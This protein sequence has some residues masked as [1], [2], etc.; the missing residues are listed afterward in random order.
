MTKRNSM[1]WRL[2]HTMIIGTLLLM[3]TQLLI[4]GGYILWVSVN[5]Q[6]HQQQQAAGALQ[7]ELQQRLQQLQQTTAQL[8]SWDDTYIFVNNANLD[9]VTR[10]MSRERL[11]RAG[12]FAVLLVDTS[13]G[14]IFGNSS[15][16]RHS[17]NP[18]VQATQRDLP[19]DLQPAYGF[20]RLGTRLLL[21]ARHPVTDSDRTQ[22]ANA[23]LIAFAELD[24]A[25]LKGLGMVDAPPPQLLLPAGDEV[26]LHPLRGQW[27]L[28][29]TSHDHHHPFLLAQTRLHDQ[30]GELPLSFVLKL[31]AQP[32]FVVNPLW[33]VI[34]AVSG[35]VVIVA[36]FWWRAH[37]YMVVPLRALGRS[38]AA[39]KP[40]TTIDQSP[41]LTSE[42]IAMVDS[43]NTL[44]GALDSERCFNRRLLGSIGDLILSV[45]HQQRLTFA[46]DAARRWLQL[47]REPLGLPLP[48]MV[49]DCS[50]EHQ[51][52]AVPMARWL[53]QLLIDQQPFTAEIW[54]RPAG[55]SQQLWRGTISGQPLADQQGAVLLAKLA[56]VTTPDG[57]LAPGLDHP[58]PA[59]PG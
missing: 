33:L 42:L 18:L 24:L 57:G 27:Q 58:V 47:A 30:G 20:A 7:Q 13:G 52:Q 31:P 34:P 1:A 45:D 11:S 22:P 23:N 38:M 48:L 10:Q 36:F 37:R 21:F 16:D 55:A 9:Y 14:L 56:M 41:H 49:Q 32:L 54:L 26:R 15:L 8:A 4:T 43:L 35:V 39:A 2:R 50:L 19:G 6:Q 3:L 51:P 12:L 59:V 44:L 46:N 25:Q 17:V 53:R 40:G 29:T 28:V 5:K